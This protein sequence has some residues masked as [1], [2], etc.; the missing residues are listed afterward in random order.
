MSENSA[1]AVV[2]LLKAQINNGPTF[3][4]LT[5]TSLPSVDVGSFAG[6]TESGVT[7]EGSN[8]KKYSDTVPIT[9]DASCGV[10]TC[11]AEIIERHLR[12]NGESGVCMYGLIFN[13]DNCPR[14]AASER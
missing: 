10:N 11:G 14:R 3:K 1:F 6:R 7:V 9:V 13:C 8:L 2:S 4:S 12:Q 5:G